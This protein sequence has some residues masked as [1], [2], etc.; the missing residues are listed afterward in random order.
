[1]DFETYLSISRCK[2]SLKEFMLLCKISILFRKRGEA[3]ANGTDSIVAVRLHAMLFR[4]AWVSA[5]RQL[6]AGRP[7][8]LTSNKA[9]LMLCLA[10]LSKRGKF[11]EVVSL[12]DGT[13][14]RFCR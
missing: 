4:L 13:K 3:L 10:K 1:M 12:Q 6:L 8:K 2:P 5:C 11:C 14:I 9:G 7:R